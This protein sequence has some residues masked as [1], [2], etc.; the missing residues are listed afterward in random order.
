MFSRGE[1][2]G[3]KILRKEFFH[4]EQRITDSPADSEK[5][6]ESR[7][8]IL[9]TYSEKGTTYITSSGYSILLFTFPP[10]QPVKDQFVPE[11]AKSRNPL[12]YS[13]K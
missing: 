7:A 8:G 13:D 4:F 2:M 11:V 10:F 6:F 3:K 1:E 9:N 5:G 12:W